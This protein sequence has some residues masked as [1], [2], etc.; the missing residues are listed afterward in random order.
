M[1]LSCLQ[2]YLHECHWLGKRTTPSL[3]VR[4]WVCG[5]LYFKVFWKLK[6]HTQIRSGQWAVPSSREPFCQ[7]TAPACVLGSSF[8]VLEGCHTHSWSPGPWL[9]CGL[10]CS[11]FL[12]AGLL[13]AAST[14]ASSQR[15]P[16]HAYRRKSTFSSSPEWGKYVRERE[17]RVAGL[18]TCHPPPKIQGV[19]LKKRAISDC[20]WKQSYPHFTGCN[21]YGSIFP[22]KTEHRKAGSSLLVSFNYM[23]RHSSSTQKAVSE[24]HPII[25]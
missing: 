11:C 1:H 20:F 7:I 22:L 17:L 2:F 14:P 10:R 3:Q 23:D 21:S 6:K 15:V 25:S 13:P 19:N 8:V 9:L 4:I 5:V 24:L 18:P 12:F 16:V